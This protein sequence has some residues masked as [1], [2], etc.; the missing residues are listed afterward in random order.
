MA[1]RECFTVLIRLQCDA[2]SSILPMPHENVP[3]ALDSFAS[4]PSQDHYLTQLATNIDLTAN[5]L[6][7]QGKAIIKMHKNYMPKRLQLF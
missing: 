3:A 2:M 1:E 7:D 5:I 6:P 4:S